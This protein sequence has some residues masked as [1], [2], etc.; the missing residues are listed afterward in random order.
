MPAGLVHGEEHYSTLPEPPGTARS[1]RLSPVAGFFPLFP[2]LHPVLAK[3]YYP[4]GIVWQESTPDHPAAPDGDHA[5][6]DKDPVT[7]VCKEP[8]AG[9]S[10]GL[11]PVQWK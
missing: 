8:V 6:G 4:S 9:Q 10:W 2:R 11:F 1:Q 3:R 5:R 7:F